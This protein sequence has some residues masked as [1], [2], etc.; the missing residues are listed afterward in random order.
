M[1]VPWRGTRV[2][3]DKSQNS[4][5]SALSRRATL[6]RG[7]MALA[8]SCGLAACASDPDPRPVV[9][10]GLAPR[11][12]TS[13]LRSRIDGG[14]KLLVSG[15]V[16]DAASLQKFYARHG[17]EPVWT[18]RKAAATSLVD[19]VMRAGDQGLDPEL[20]HA[21]LL[22]RRAE[23]PPLDR[24][25][26]M[27]DAFLSYANALARGG[28]PVERRRDDQVLTPDPIDVTVVLDEAANSSDAG[29]VIEALAP[30]TPTYRA[31]RE[32]LKKYRAGTPVA[33][34]MAEAS[35][36]PVVYKPTDKAKAGKIAVTR[37]SLAIPLPPMPHGKP[38][39]KVAEQPSA[40]RLRTL[41][42]NLERQRWL[43]R[44][45]P[46][47]RVVVN[48]AAETLVLYRDDE[49]VFTTR[50]VVGED[51]V[52]NQ[53]PEFRATIDASF[54]NPPWVIPA[55]IAKAEILPK[56]DHEPDY[57]KK[58]GMVL[59][60]GGEVE[61]L[62]GPQAGLGLIMFDMP[63]RFDVYLH[64]TPD[65]Y[66][67][68]LDNRRLSHGCIRVQNPLQFAALL[69]DE[70]IESINQRIARG[71]VTGDTTRHSLPI[72]MPVFVVYQTAAMD[73]N[74]AMQFYP[75]FYSRDAE[76]FRKLQRA[77]PQP[78]PPLQQTDGRSPGTRST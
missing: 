24:D 11:P 69:L 30:D 63:N 60:A 77:T 38:H 6:A 76:I 51:I 75:D 68:N 74:G 59:L 19:A 56:L 27:S 18:T 12:A 5:C 36:V 26:V 55:D 78:R 4:A 31:L 54:F 40:N 8:A 21:S 44:P 41:I 25:L 46:P 2:A 66:I 50:V 32:A 33:E 9:V 53:S 15:E 39:G 71:L 61:Q 37:R 14:P 67:F 48:T 17:F 10:P 28:V 34:N 16:L 23:L 22:Q 49:P 35:I 43:P 3:R 42:V 73:P 58:N 65:R 62:P 1:R 45:M 57:L 20:F 52:H 72:P 47:D 7:A 64:D 70:P 13:A 29:A